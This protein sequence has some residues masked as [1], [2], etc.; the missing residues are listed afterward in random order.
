MAIAN[1]YGIMIDEFRVQWDGNS[2][3]CI[4]AAVIPSRVYLSAECV[5]TSNSNSLT[6]GPVYTVVE[7][8][9]LCSRT[10]RSYTYSAYPLPGHCLT[11]RE[12]AH[13]ESTFLP[14]EKFRWA[15]DNSVTGLY[16]KRVTETDDI[17]N[18]VVACYTVV[19]HLSPVNE[20]FWRLKYG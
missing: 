1:G 11:A 16:V 2:M 4:R 19:T 20:T 10:I 14:A 8:V 17:P 6:S 15:H 5:T 12:L 3:Q 7:Q 9:V 13:L 18:S